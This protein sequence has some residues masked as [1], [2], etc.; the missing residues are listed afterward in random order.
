M[1]TIFRIIT[2]TILTLWS[3]NGIAQVTVTM[4]DMTNILTSPITSINHCS[5][6][7]FNLETTVRL[8]FD[9][10]LTKLSTTIVNAGTI[11]IYYQK[12]STDSKMEVG[13]PYSVPA[14]PN[15]NTSFSA[16]FDIEL[17]A[18]NFNI[19]GGTLFAIY[20]PFGGNENR[21]T[22]NYPI[23]KDETPTFTLSTTPTS[24][25]C[26]STSPVI[27][28][29]NNIH[30]SSG[31]KSY[32]W[33]IGSGWN[34]NGSTAPTNLTT[35]NTTN[36]LTLVPTAFPPNNVQVT[37][38]LDD[39]A[40][41]Q[42]TTTVNL[43]DYDPNYSISGVNTICNTATYSI[44]SLPSGT[45]ITS[46]SSSDTNIVT[47]SAINNYQ[48]TVT[49][50]GNGSATISA[51]VQNSCGQSKPFT[52]NIIVGSPSFASGS[53]TGKSNPFSGDF[54]PYTVPYA[55][56]ASNYDWY[57][58]VG[59]VLGTSID[60]WEI[61]LDQN[62]NFVNIT[63]GNPGLAVLVCKVSNS[64][65][66]TTKYKYITALSTSGGGGGGGTD[67]CLTSLKF[68]SNPM[69]SGVSTNKVIIIEDPCLDPTMKNVDVTTT[70]HTITI[71]NR[72]SSMIYS[73]NQTEKEFNIS[74]LQKGFYI[75]KY[76]N[77]KGKNITKN[78]II[79]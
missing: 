31:T 45:T 30:G 9:V 10:S 3:S 69:K 58:D 73:K 75:V 67:P 35:Y 47:I 24:I 20:Q 70:N 1:K 36:T 17:Y 38:V 60:G 50:T 66:T 4:S 68:S 2:L 8:Q 26:N 21:T 37:P 72:Y 54:E 16:S 49:K 79:N 23:I 14:S 41:S 29:V 7:D 11:Q 19:S 6:I 13:A 78:L 39:Q 44:N 61:V 57:F 33:V 76:K 65:G 18:N 5:T 15:F 77:T 32:N 74:N 59:G 42:L 52:K 71:F 53:M 51:I 64:C 48:A 12:S 63:V 22:C 34:Y 25:N 46:W 43:S 55:S 56:G 28:T 62:T 27:F 40:Y